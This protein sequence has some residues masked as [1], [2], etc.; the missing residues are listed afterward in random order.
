MFDCA[1]KWVTFAAAFV[2]TVC[3]IIAGLVVYPDIVGQAVTQNNDFVFAL[4]LGPFC[5]FLFFGWLGERIVLKFLKR[6][7]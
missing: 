3:V 6:N 4:F 5:V 1:M 7:K 2:L